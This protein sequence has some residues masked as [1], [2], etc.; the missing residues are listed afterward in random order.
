[1]GNS[2][3]NLNPS[4]VQN[5]LKQGWTLQDFCDDLDVSEEFLLN[6]IEKHSTNK[7]YANFPRQVKQNE[8]I[9]EKK[10]RSAEKKSNAEN[11]TPYEVLETSETS[12]TLASASET[13]DSN[14]SNISLPKENL[15]P[16]EVEIFNLQNK[17]GEK[18]KE[19][20][21][22]QKLKTQVSSEHDSLL[23]LTVRTQNNV[24]RLAKELE[25]EKQK[26]HR[27]STRLT[28]LTNHM[29]SLDKEIENFETSIENIKS[30][31]KELRKISIFVSSSCEITF[32][33][34]VAIPDSWKKLYPMLLE[35][36][37]VENL[38]VKQVQQLAK[39]IVIFEMLKE[40]EAYFEFVFEGD[41]K[42][43]DNSLKT[44]FELFTEKDG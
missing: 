4:Y 34:D 2:K 42:D 16:T 37:L 35:D 44:L 28:V 3:K 24:D 15:D 17:I 33:K 20:L 27:L 6:F 7:V 5:K 30:K 8:Q 29:T 32:N 13:K 25:L 21:D 11:S 1:M 36:S 14:T 23:L 9:A 18:E 31:I 10:R 39:L 38:T 26:Y 19:L 41:A 12:P 22:K 43:N 40:E